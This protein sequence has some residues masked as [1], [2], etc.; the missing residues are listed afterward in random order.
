MR[1]FSGVSILAAIALTGCQNFAPG[2]AT[3]SLEPAAPTTLDELK[4]S[5]DA[6]AP[7]ADGDDLTYAIQWT[8]NGEA[9]SE[10]TGA[11]TVAAD[12]IAKGEE[13]A[14]LVTANDGQSD[15]PTVTATVIVGNTAPTAVA[16]LSP[17][18]PDNTQD[19]VVTA[20]GSDVDGDSVELIY[21]WLLDG[22]ATIHE[23]TSIPK[24]ELLSGQIWEVLVTP[25]DQE[26]VGEVVSASTT[27]TN[28]APV[29]NTVDITPN[30]AR[31]ADELLVEISASDTDGHSISYTY[32]WTVASVSVSTA[33]SLSG[34]FV[35]DDE[36]AVVVTPS[37]GFV[38]GQPVSASITIENTLPTL[39]EATV[40]PSEIYEESV[41]SCEGVGWDDPDG[42]SQTDLIVWTVNSTDVASTSSISGDLFSRGDAVHCTVTPFDGL[43]MGLPVSSSPITVTNSIPVVSS[44]G[45]STLSPTSVSGIT[46][47]PV[48]EDAD[49]DALSFAYYWTVG[50]QPV[51]LPTST[52]TLGKDD[53][54]VGDTISVI[55]SACDSESCGV[56]VPSTEV[57][58]VVNSPPEVTSV[59]LSPS[60]GATTDEVITATVLSSDADDEPVAVSYEWMVNGAAVGQSTATLD[61][62]TYFV[63]GDTI[64][65]NV[66]PTD[67]TDD[68]AAVVSDPLV[69]VN[70]A[71]TAPVV[72]VSPTRPVAGDD[73]LRCTIQTDSTDADGDAVSYSYA[74]SV[75]GVDAGNSSSTVS[76]GTLQEGETWECTV[77]PDDGDDV[78]S[79]GSASVLV[80]D[81]PTNWVNAYYEDFSDGVA[82]GFEHYGGAC[83]GQS[84]EFDGS[85]YLWRF[86]SDWNGARLPIP[87]IGSAGLAFET[88]VRFFEES[89]A[90]AI[91]WR[92][93]EVAWDAN[94]DAGYTVNMQLGASEQ[95][96]GEDELCVDFCNEGAELDLESESWFNY[97]VEEWD[98]EYK[99]FIDEQLILS[100]SISDLASAGD[101]LE[102]VGSGD[103]GTPVL[104]VDYLVIQEAVTLSENTPPG[105][106]VV[107]LRPLVPRANAD[108]LICSVDSVSFDE[109]G[110]I[111]EYQF[112][113]TVNG[114]SFDQTSDTEWAGDTVPAV[115]VTWGDHW[116]CLVVPYDG[117]ESGTSAAIDVVVVP[118]DCAAL[119]SADSDGSLGVISQ[120]ASLSLDDG[121]FTVEAWVYAS[122]ELGGEDRRILGIFDGTYSQWAL[123]YNATEGGIGALFSDGV[124]QVSVYSAETLTVDSWH[125]VAVTR[126]VDAF[127]V[128]V[129]GVEVATADNSSTFASLSGDLYIGNS[130][131]AQNGWYGLIDEVRISSTARYSDGFTPA[132]SWQRDAKTVGLWHLDS[133]GSILYD[134]S[135]NG[136]HGE[137]TDGIWSTESSCDV[138][139]FE[140][141][142]GGAH[143]C[144]LTESGVS[145]FGSDTYGQLEGVTGAYRS[146]HSGLNDACAIGFNDQIECWGRLDYS[147]GASGTAR[148]LSMGQFHRCSVGSDST[149]RCW[150]VSDGSIFD[151]GQVSDAP[152]VQVADVASGAFY[153]C[154]VGLDGQLS[155]WGRDVY[156]EASPPSGTYE[157]LSAGLYHACALDTLGQV[158]CWGASDGLSDDYGQVSQAPA[159]SFLAVEN[160][161]YHSC[162]LDDFGSIS[163]W[164]RDL[165]GQSSAP[166]GE[167]VA[168]SAGSMH[169]CGVDATGGVVCWGSDAGGQVTG[170]SDTGG[171]SDTGMG[172]VPPGE[173]ASLTLDGADDFAVLG[174][175]SDLAV[176]GS[177]NLSLEFWVRPDTV[178]TAMTLLQWGDDELSLE[179][180]FI[181]VQLNEDGEVV[182]TLRGQN[183]A[184]EEAQV[185]S[186]TVLTPGVWSHVH[187]QREVGTSLT[188]YL[189]G[190]LEATVAEEAGAVGH[191]EARDLLLGV[192]Y[193]FGTETRHEAFAGS[194][195]EVR[196]WNR[197]LD[198]VE[199]VDKSYEQ[200]DPGSETSLVAYWPLDEGA[201]A[202]LS[203]L[204]SGG[205]GQVYDDVNPAGTWT[206]G[207]EE[208]REAPGLTDTGDTGHTGHTG[209]ADTAMAPVSCLD[210]TASVGGTVVFT[211][212]FDFG[213][214][215]SMTYPGWTAY[216]GIY[217]GNKSYNPVTATVD[218]LQVSDLF[219]S[220]WVS[221]DFSDPTSWRITRGALNC[222]STDVSGGVGNALSDL[223]GFYGTNQLFSADD[224]V[225]MSFDVQVNAAVDQVVLT[226][227]AAAADANCDT[228]DGATMLLCSA[229][230]WISLNLDRDAQTVTVWLEEETNALT[231]PLALSDFPADNTVQNV[232]LQLEP[233]ASCP[234]LLD[235][236]HSGI[237]FPD[238][239]L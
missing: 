45:F 227:S 15:G 216:P 88:R 116:E 209:G 84:G 87:D 67:G 191:V 101:S 42:D 180:E 202:A 165:E 229:T 56:G 103:C 65:V 94:D 183:G 14:A 126:A 211:G 32:D 48:A 152:T 73:K 9:L 132:R 76:K 114:S 225:N 184:N 164:G 153:S 121:D 30:P 221:D 117:K 213:S 158:T 230:P 161:D 105:A 118:R 146:V 110:D 40:A 224:G 20:T 186:A 75:D 182:A 204:A 29:I 113:W 108:D 231:A 219:G 173:C 217:V 162:A 64:T 6:D 24:E 166:S 203:E 50:G 154:A 141:A 26:A 81:W 92:S 205:Y 71:P 228:C 151:F 124:S 98:G 54:D 150:G 220:P 66:T 222:G 89:T 46:A 223:N 49:S 175:G 102:F 63:K 97:R 185:T 77:T 111:A 236:G 119:E 57:A 72:E 85:V 11:T 18:D 2:P 155:C 104:E 137:M 8:R 148:D 210:V 159:G 131:A 194:F 188:L 199:I 16:T 130:E 190:V 200:L 128:W 80:A 179:N 41:L 13:W 78:G 21:A 147:L 82:D 140:V 181:W 232:A 177:G 208:C 17:E 10:L 156:G 91:R 79:A 34:A 136:S 33:A 160:G 120:N 69:I 196:A 23:G 47:L 74:W 178:G 107:N 127:S 198:E 138:F 215:Q 19:L 53:F 197:L 109:D 39:T 125:H 239:G 214:L 52:A 192:A 112:F 44:V 31:V 25:R 129:D 133:R 167:F 58:T 95:T 139:Q 144:V 195:S 226:M 237:N 100:G 206:I 122:A 22:D 62:T 174:N 123:E 5:I 135:G 51:M 70:S 83:G 99:V 189:D 60:S 207:S 233:S 12:Q 106:P 212:A 90:S 28:G 37:D 43:E 59:T 1:L 169:S 115:S 234:L 193:D 238:T 171:P 172:V 143:T 168:I 201:G 7:D 4:L 96:F 27:I 163:C 170:G 134:A 149:L 187:L 68:G 157:S 38:Q 176:L 93:N 55:A 3:I 35:R 145:C 36:V 235:S 142:A 61:G 86:T 218:N